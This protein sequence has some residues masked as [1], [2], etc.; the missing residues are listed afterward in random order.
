MLALSDV[1]RNSVAKAKTRQI[2][3]RQGDKFILLL[4]PIISQRTG[5]ANVMSTKFKVTKHF[6]ANNLA[7]NTKFAEIERGQKVVRI[8]KYKV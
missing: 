8:S 1:L 7:F 4:F 3:N 6:D 5:E 2:S